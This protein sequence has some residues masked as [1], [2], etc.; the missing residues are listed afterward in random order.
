MQDLLLV[1]QII[2]T[3]KPGPP[4]RLCVDTAVECFYLP[5]SRVRCP[6][7]ARR[8]LTIASYFFA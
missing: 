7:R 2:N 8:D 4:T 6:M 1:V 5:L 3:Q